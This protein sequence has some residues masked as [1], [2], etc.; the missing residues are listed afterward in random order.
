MKIKQELPPNY[1]QLCAAFPSIVNEPDAI[2]AYGFDIFNPGGRELPAYKIAHEEV[3]GRQQLEV[4]VEWWWQTY[5]EDKDFRLNEEIP[6]HHVDYK[7]FCKEYTD[8]NQQAQYLDH[9][10]NLLSSELYGNI[11]TKNGAMKAIRHG[12]R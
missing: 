11:I 9:L 3:H 10:A 7:M 6:A 12:T 4:G 8:R 2:F 5:I 1:P